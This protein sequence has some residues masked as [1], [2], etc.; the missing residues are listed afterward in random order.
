MHIHWN[1][2]SISAQNDSDTDNHTDD[3]TG[4]KFTQWTDNTNFQP[5]AP[6]VHRFTGRVPVCYNRQRHPTSVKTLPHFSVWTARQERQ[7]PSMGNLKGLDTSHNRNWYM[8]CNKI[9]CYVNSTKNKETRT[10]FKYREYNIRLCAT[11][12]FAVYHT[13]LHF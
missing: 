1:T 13:K 5:T 4:T 7:V 9:C 3:I 8:Q 10:K 2:K 12:C 11:P 6:I